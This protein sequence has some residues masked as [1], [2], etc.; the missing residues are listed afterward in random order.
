[1]SQLNVC[2]LCGFRT[3]ELTTSDGKHLP[4]CGLCAV[5]ADL[6]AKTT[7]LRVSNMLLREMNEVRALARK[8]IESRPK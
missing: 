2:T 6:D 7:F 3:S 1:M 5:A 8:A 4:A